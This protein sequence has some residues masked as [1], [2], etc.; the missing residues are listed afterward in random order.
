MPTQYRRILLKP[1]SIVSYKVTKHRCVHGKVTILTGTRRSSSSI[2]ADANCNRSRAR[3]GQL[4]TS[5]THPILTRHHVDYVVSRHYGD[6][7]RFDVLPFTAIPLACL[8]MIAYL[9]GTRGECRSNG[10]FQARA[11]GR[12]GVILSFSVTASVNV[13]HSRPQSMWPLGQAAWL[14]AVSRTPGVTCSSVLY[15]RA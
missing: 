15:Q 8:S 12:S 2:I 6:R 7:A 10:T 13:K 9:E 5:K 4:H 1:Q 11:V 3:V 14:K